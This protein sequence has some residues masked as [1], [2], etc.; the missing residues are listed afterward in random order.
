M[1][2]VLLGEVEVLDDAGA[3][4]AVAGTNLRVLLAMLALRTGRVV[5]TEQ[6][7][8]AIWGDD[9]PHA[10]KN[11]LQGLVSKLRRALGSSELVVMRSGGYALELDPESVDTHRFER[12]VAEGLTEAQPERAVAL[13]TEAERLWGGD[14][15]AEFAY[16]NFASLDIARLTEL[17]LTAIEARL[18]AQLELGHQPTT[19]GELEGI[20][21]LHPLRERPRGLLMTA[22]YRSGRQ[23]DALQ[24]FRECRLALVEELGLDPSP[25]LCQLEAAILAQ[26]PA[27]AGPVR[28]ADRSPGRRSDIPEPLTPLIGR[29]AELETL[30]AVVDEHR[31]VTLVGPG[32]V[33]KTRLALEVAGA[34][35]A[36]L[37][38]GGVLVELAPVGN[39]GDVRTTI[40][41]ALDLP[42]PSRVVELIGD[43]QLLAVLDN[44]EHVITAA[45][46]AAEELLRHCPGLHVIATSREGLRVPGEVI[47]PVPPLTA[48]DAV[49]LFVTRS[50][51]A[52]ADPAGC[53]DQRAAID[54]ICARLDGLPLAI[55]LAAARTRA[56]SVPQLASRLTDRFRLLTGGSR[57]AL[58]RQQTL[59]AVVDWS[60]D[61]LFEDEQRAFERLSVFPGGC[62]MATATA[63]C[64][65]SS[66]PATDLED[67]VYALVDKSLVTILPSSGELRVTQL[68]TLAQYG[69]EKLAKRGDAES[70][71]DAMTTHFAALCARSASA[72]TGDEQRG[73]LLAVDRERENL[74]AALEWAV[75][76]GDAEAAMTIAGGSS[77]PHWL[78]GRVAEGR[79]WLEEAFA[80]DRPVSDTAR[81]LALT[82]RALLVFQSGVREGVDDDLGEALAVYRALGDLEGITWTSSFWAEIASARG[83]VEEGRRRRW[84]NFA[85]YESRP[86]D[87]IVLV[88]RAYNRAKIAQVESDLVTAEHWYRDAVDGLSRIDRPVMRAMSLGMVAEF[89]E[90]AGRHRE[91]ISALEEA[92]DTCETFGLRGFLGALQ[93]RLGWALLHASD[94]ARAEDVYRRALDVGRRLD[95]T[96][97]VFLSLTGLAVV[98][99]SL[100][101]HAEAASAATEAL[102]LHGSIGPRR[103]A[104]RLDAD[105]DVAVGAAACCT[106]LAVTAAESGDIDQAASFLRRSD[107]LRASAGTTVPPFQQD[108][109][110]RARALTT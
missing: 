82:G 15:L 67:L 53:G 7:V 87:A 83:D 61:L 35:A 57:T 76:R 92:V 42:D 78:G 88:L 99:R 77:W 62:D 50:R 17:R 39:P 26:D 48:S 12:L 59:R 85:F 18:E 4:V 29:T 47:W 38:D 5:T 60:Y 90:R 105:A 65:D 72:F 106:V 28:T 75:D 2:I 91:A 43:R 74:R 9:P 31:L 79:R 44:C 11:G 102:A 51:A 19:I 110:D 52:G 70:V 6:L 25:E 37:A 95:N 71:R 104:N 8:E 108:D 96:P 3:D 89:D 20:V 101:R 63:V 36:T 94:L 86:D 24:V 30:A 73:W 56:F 45:A 81:A 54:D 14:A 23:A 58:P 33:G 22:L 32:G 103:L 98:R 100:R 109:L 46:E 66:L 40:A 16:D 41:T 68:Q 49:E 21:A 27:L 80:V 13:L 69:R 84:E 93:V 55:E 107:E 97:V 64:S 1:R 10:L 34:K